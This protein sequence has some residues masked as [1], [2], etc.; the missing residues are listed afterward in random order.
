MMN[1][2]ASWLTPG[3]D[4]LI[5]TENQTFRGAFQTVCG[6]FIVLESRRGHRHFVREDLIES[7]TAYHERAGR[8]AR[9]TRELLDEEHTT[10]T[11]DSQESSDEELSPEDLL[12]PLDGSIDKNKTY[13]YKPGDRIPLP[14]IAPQRSATKPQAPKPYKYSPTKHIPHNS[15]DK[16]TLSEILDELEAKEDRALIPSEDLAEVR[17]SGTIKMRENMKKYGFIEGFD[18][19]KTNYWFPFSALTDEDL[20]VTDEVIFCKGSNEK[21]HTASGIASP[22]T[23]HRLLLLVD[24]I[25]KTRYYNFPIVLPLLETML[26]QYPDNERILS[27]YQEVKERQ[28]SYSKRKLG[29]D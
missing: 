23:I 10:E 7:F 5:V 8:F 12:S 9:P 15:A 1:D 26:D 14:H 22:G 18:E 21:G 29:L 13:I 27:K 6:D 25:L 24:Y 11:T 28:E 4:I 19:E 20:S 16:P 17:P 2:F 3:Q